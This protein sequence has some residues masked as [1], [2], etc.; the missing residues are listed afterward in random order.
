MLKCFG[1]I[2]NC[3]IFSRENINLAKYV[4]FQKFEY[5]QNWL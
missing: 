1:M 3:E 5:I 2:W 4:F